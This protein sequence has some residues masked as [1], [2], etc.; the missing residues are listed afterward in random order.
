MPT[1]LQ[2]SLS[3]LLATCI[4]G[5]AFAAP[6]N[7]EPEAEVLIEKLED[8]FADHQVD[9]AKSSARLKRKLEKGQ[10]QANGDVGE[11]IDVMMDV[12]EEAFAEDGLFR[13]LAAMFGD[14]AENLD[15]DTDG[16]TTTLSFDGANIAEIER[17]KSRDSEDSFSIIGLGKYLSVDRETIVKDGKSKTR[18]V[19]DMD[20]ENEIDITLPSPN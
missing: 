16:G 12:L 17:K 1:P 5:S 18:I 20:G 15:V 9:I 4:A 8:T 13:D 14:F 2:F 3:C 11:E 19:I 10:A 7:M 6:P